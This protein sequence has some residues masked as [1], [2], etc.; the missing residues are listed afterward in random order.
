MPRAHCESQSGTMT[1]GKREV[2]GRQTATSLYNLSAAIDSRPNM[3]RD[4]HQDGGAYLSCS[5]RPKEKEIAQGLRAAQ[6]VVL[7][8]FMLRTPWDGS[9]RCH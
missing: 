9:H 7:H 8:A 5:A 4:A 6:A 3:V 1:E 2:N